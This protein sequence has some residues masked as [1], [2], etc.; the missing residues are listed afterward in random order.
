MHPCS[1][2][3]LMTSEG[4]RRSVYRAH[5]IYY[6]I[7]DD[8]IEIMRILGQEDVNTELESKLQ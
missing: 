4:Y 3:P 7:E 6:Q 8:S 2:K 1:G 5:A